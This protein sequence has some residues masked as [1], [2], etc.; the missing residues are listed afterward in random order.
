MASSANRKK[1]HG[2]EHHPGRVKI[3]LMAPATM[4]TM[5]AKD[6]CSGRSGL[7]G[8]YKDNQVA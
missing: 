4:A 1:A 6:G 3:K 2:A 8:M 7:A 5:D